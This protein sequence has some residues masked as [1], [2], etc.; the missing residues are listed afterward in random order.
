MK[1]YTEYDKPIRNKYD[2]ARLLL[3]RECGWEEKR[4][5]ELHVKVFQSLWKY[6]WDTFISW[7][8]NADLFGCAA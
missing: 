4:E 1:A 3:R 8:F 5:R 7:L 6:K 2:S